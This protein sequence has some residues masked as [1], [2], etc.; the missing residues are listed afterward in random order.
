MCPF[1]LMI[2][3]E[4]R[5]ADVGPVGTITR[6]VAFNARTKFGSRPPAG[7]GWAGGAVGFAAA[8]WVAVGATG[9]AATSEGFGAT[10][11]VATAAT[12]FETAVGASV[13]VAAGR[14]VGVGVTRLSATA[15]STS[16]P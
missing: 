2:E 8:A 6:I 5:L 15:R 4:P 16:A 3:P 10:V 7:V 14:T 12:G 1:G 9:F 13:A 11:A